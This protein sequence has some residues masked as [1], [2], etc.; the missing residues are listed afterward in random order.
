MQQTDGILIAGRIN[1]ASAADMG[2]DATGGPAAALAFRK[3]GT[4][5]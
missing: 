1:A 2:G 5:S 4:G 3:P